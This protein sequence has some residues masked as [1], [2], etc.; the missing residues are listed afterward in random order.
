MASPVASTESSAG[1]GLLPCGSGWASVHPVGA[2]RL[3]RRR[4][5]SGSHHTAIAPPPPAPTRGYLPLDDRR[6]GADQR[7]S[8]SAT[9]AQTP[10]SSPSTGGDHTRKSRWLESS[11][12]RRDS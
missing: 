6:A 8:G 5:G 4:G 3:Q 7:P 1:D 11:A 9:A 12:I 10:P 2:H